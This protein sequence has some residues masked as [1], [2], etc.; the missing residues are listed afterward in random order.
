MQE[1][2]LAFQNETFMTL[3][4]AR[5]PCTQLMSRRCKNDV[6]PST[7]PQMG[8]WVIGKF[9]LAVGSKLSRE[10]GWHFVQGV[11]FVG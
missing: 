3:F 11:V 6:I 2:F 4:Y 7:L 5:R 1:M 8:G 9:P 10:G